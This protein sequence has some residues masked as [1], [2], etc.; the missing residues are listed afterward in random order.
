VTPVTDEQADQYWA[1]RHP[2]SQLG[3]WASSQSGVLDSRATLEK[4][5]LE[6]R[7]EFAGRAIPRPPFWSGYCL[8]P[9][10][11]EFWQALPHRLNERVCYRLVDGEWSVSLLY[12]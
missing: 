8:L 9:D 2:E 5:V 3:A 10:R 4:K 1:T 7:D 6:Y 12:P 11:V